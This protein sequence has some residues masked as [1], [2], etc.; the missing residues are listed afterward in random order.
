MSNNDLRFLMS[1]CGFFLAL[2]WPRP[3][4]P[5]SRPIPRGLAGPP[6]LSLNSAGDALNPALTLMR[7]QHTKLVA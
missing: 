6:T 3:G 7:D 1:C 5:P 2:V 4:L